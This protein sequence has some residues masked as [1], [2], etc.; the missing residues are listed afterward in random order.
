MTELARLVAKGTKMKATD[1]HIDGEKQVYFRL[2]NKLQRQEQEVDWPIL[3]K[4]LKE[5]EERNICHVDGLVY[6]FHSY[7]TR[8]GRAFAIRLLYPF[9]P[10][11]ED[12]DWPIL[13]RC[14][15]F[16]SGLV[17][18]TGSTGA[19]KTTL[20]AQMIDYLNR[21]EAKHIL[22]LEDP[23]EWIHENNQSLVSQR[24]LGV[25]VLSYREGLKDGLR[26]DPDIILVGEIREET[27]LDGALE[28]AETGHLVF[29]TLHTGRAVD[30]IPRLIQMQK[31]QEEYSRER[32][33]QSLRAVITQEVRY[34][35]GQRCHYRDILITTP[36]VSQ[37]IRGH[38]EYQL[39]N[40]MQTGKT[41]GMRVM[42]QDKGR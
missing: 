30:T 15:H 41:W 38:K 17:L 8:K 35:E 5:K 13:E 42:E 9:A 25:D 19:G 21:T 4:E 1:I 39:Y 14:C 31:G 27:A 26:E 11:E 37:L 10:L 23:I 22:T 36:A 16:S 29:S 3:W 2:C 24:A 6:R 33:A 20:L 32:L 28:A 7:Q 34:E 40:A 12:R 18:V